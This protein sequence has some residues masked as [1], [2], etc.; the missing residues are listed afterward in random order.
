MILGTLQKI[1][2]VSFL[3]HWKKFENLRKCS[4]PQILKIWESAV[5][6]KSYNKLVEKSNQLL[7]DSQKEIEENKIK[8]N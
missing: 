1:K 3:G 8:V 2:I 6:P 7:K 5:S 4:V